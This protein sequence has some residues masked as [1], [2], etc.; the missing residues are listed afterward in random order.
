MYAD[1][2]PPNSGRLTEEYLVD[3]AERIGLDTERFRADMGSRRVADAVAADFEEGQ[4][5]GV[6]GTPA[7][8][9]NGSPIMGAQPTDVFVEA[10]EQAAKAAKAEKAAE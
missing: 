5:I 6:T 8:L 9:V 7:F 10:V 4:Q 3:V 2:Q 1:Q